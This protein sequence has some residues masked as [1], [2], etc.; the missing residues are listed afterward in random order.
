MTYYVAPQYQV[1]VLPNGAEQHRIFVLDSK[2]VVASTTVVGAGSTVPSDGTPAP[3]GFYLYQD[4]LR[5]TVQ[6]FD[7]Q[8]HAQTTL[9]YCPFGEI[10]ALQGPDSVQQKFTGKEW[11]SSLN[12]YYFGARYYDGGLGRF[13]TSDDRLGAPLDHRDA[14]NRFSYVTNDPANYIGGVLGGLGGALTEGVTSKIS[15]LAAPWTQE[16]FNPLLRGE[17]DMLTTAGLLE[18]IKSSPT[19]IRR[20]LESAVKNNYVLTLPGAAF[21]ALD[22]GVG[23]EWQ[24]AGKRSI[25]TSCGVWLHRPHRR[26]RA[27]ARQPV[28]GGH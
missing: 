17:R 25:V 7:A 23:V 16:D 12:L 18:Q 4:H 13:I 15:T 28:P 1:T 27:E 14:L 10:D 11:D 5:N 9:R 20:V 6:Q 22:A 19:D 8:G 24:P 3:G 21:S 26:C 2:A